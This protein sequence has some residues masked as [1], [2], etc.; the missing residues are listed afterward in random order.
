MLH[1]LLHHGRI[2]RAIGDEEAI[3][4]LTSKGWE[5]VVPRTDHDLNASL[6]QTP[7]L[8]VLQTNIQAQYTQGSSRWVFQGV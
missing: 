1:G 6:E 4:V 2:T 8:I 7:Q 5:I 3:V